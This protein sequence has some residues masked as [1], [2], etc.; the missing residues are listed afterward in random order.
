M[1]ILIS[2]CTDKAFTDGLLPMAHMT[3]GSTEAVNDNTAQAEAKWR[4]R[5]HRRHTSDLARQAVS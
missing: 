5:L 4:L 3:S 1:R 2:A